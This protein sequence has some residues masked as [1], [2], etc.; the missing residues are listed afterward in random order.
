MVINTMVNEIAEFVSANKFPIKYTQNNG[1]I[2]ITPLGL[3]ISEIDEI[4]IKF[5]GKLINGEIIINEE[6]R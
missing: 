2:T 1:I 5:N 6:G 4:C 3:D